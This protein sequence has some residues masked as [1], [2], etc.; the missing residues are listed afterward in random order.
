MKKQDL[1]IKWG[2]IT[3]FFGHAFA[4]IYSFGFH[5]PDEHFQILEWANYFVG[6]TPDGSHLPWEFASQ[7]RPWF[8][9][10]LHALFMKFFTV[11]GIYNPFSSATFFRLV[12]AALNLW[13]LK[14]LWDY[15]QKKYDL[16]SQWFLIFGCMW[17]FP[18]IH[19]RTSSENLS[20]IFT[21]FALVMLSRIPKAKF[22]I[23]LRSFFFAGIL[24]GFA[25]I[26]RFQI[27]LGIAGIAIALL[28]RDRGIRK[29][30][31]SMLGGFIL[32]VL[33]G[34]FLD[35][36][37]YGNWVFTPYLYFKV[38]IVQH[39]AATFNPYP[40][41]QYFFW[42]LQLLPVISIPLF[43]GMIGFSLKHRLDFFGWFSLSFF[44]LHCLI[45]NKEYRFLFPLLNFVP[46]MAFAYFQQAYKI[47]KNK[48]WIYRQGTKPAF[49]RSYLVLSA[50]S[51]FISSFH[52]ASMRTLWAH[53]AVHELSLNHPNAEWISNRNF[54]EQ[55]KYVTHYYDLKKN[56]GFNPEKLHIYK[57][58]ETL[59][60][61]L[62]NFKESLVMID[63]N[64]DQYAA[65]LIQTLESSNCK[66]A[67]NS[68]LGTVAR[69]ARIPF[70]VVYFC[71][72]N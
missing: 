50:I 35:R 56:A 57:S 29:T 58:V 64:Y 60:E 66:L 52:G 26:S 9:P 62:P 39:V 40:W 33:L 34:V 11:L 70:Q 51:F 36:W 48:F 10:M 38:N 18:Y 13:S 8:Q 6:N 61:L 17:F 42:V 31:W 43:H 22:N 24:F 72:S 63:A 67:T 23:D 41:Y 15:F 16:S 5:H 47:G 71:G 27:A 12:Y 19:V 21:S 44:F 45:T 69:Y 65:D 28:I 46:L 25:F 30:H 55:G 7:I 37:G 3:L 54:L 14:F 49:L 20:G 68:F 53:H 1:Y 59:S 4:A 32:P 2:W